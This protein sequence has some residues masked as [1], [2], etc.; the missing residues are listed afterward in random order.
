MFRA[1][2][3]HCR[4]PV[5]LTIV[6]LSPVRNR[7]IRHRVV[8]QVQTWG[9][10]L[11]AIHH[12]HAQPGGHPSQARGLAVPT[13]GAWWSLVAGDSLLL[14]SGALLHRLIISTVSLE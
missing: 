14:R 9:N 13:V 10:T 11:V 2:V 3:S 12:H 6:K 5:S 4:A 8:F 1:A 7:I